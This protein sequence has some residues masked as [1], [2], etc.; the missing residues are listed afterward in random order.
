MA[1][2]LPEHPPLLFINAGGT[3]ASGPYDDPYHPPE[4]V[5]T[6]KGEQSPIISAV[7]GLHLPH[8]HRLSWLPDRE[9]AYVKDSQLF[10]PEDIQQLAMLIANA[11]E[12]NHF[13]IGHGTDA[14]VKNAKALQVALRDLKRDG[15]LQ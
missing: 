1:D 13:V 5:E 14:M 3:I 9:A 7:D 15:V 8:V 6:L 4:F 12:F 11:V 2:Q 10:G